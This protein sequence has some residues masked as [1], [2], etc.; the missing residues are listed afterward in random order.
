M[1]KKNWIL[2][3]MGAILVAASFL[4]IGFSSHASAQK[5]KSTCC[6]QKTSAGPGAGGGK[7]DDK[8]NSPKSGETILD[9]LSRQFLFISPSGY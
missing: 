4:I 9:N 6:C 7:C 8:A 3:G 2:S 5:D 1:K